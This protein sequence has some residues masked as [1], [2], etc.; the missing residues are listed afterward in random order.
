MLLFFWNAA[1]EVFFLPGQPHFWLFMSALSLGISGVNFVMGRQ[2][3]MRAPEITK[4]IF[5]FLAVIL[6]TAKY[7]GGL[8]F[9]VFGGN[10][11]GGKH[12]VYVLGALL[13]YLALTAQRIPVA[14]SGQVVALYFLSGI[15]FILSNLVYLLGPGFYVL[16]YFL[17]GSVAGTQAASDMGYNVVSRYA[18]LGPVATGLFCFVLA[19]WG[20]RGTLSIRNPW[21]LLLAIIAIAAAFLSGFRSVAAIVF[22]LFLVQFTVEGLWKTFW[23]PIMLGGG[24]LSL[25][26]L[27]LFASRMPAAVQRVLSVFPVNIDPTVRA[28]AENSAFWRFEM[29][30]VV[31]QE[32]P[33]YF[34]MGK[35]YSIDPT[36]LYLVEEGMK[37]GILPDYE[38]AIVAG[39]YH[40][41]L[42]SVIIPFGIFG[43]IGFLWLL[44]A[45]IRVLYSN[46]RYGD[47]KLIVINRLLLS[48]FLTESI[49]FFAVFGALSSQM[50]MFLGVL[51]LSVSLNGGVCRKAV[52]VRKAAEPLPL[53]NP[54]LV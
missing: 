23:L 16:Y 49:L 46:C 33:Q 45:G 26:P 29:F 42:L 7:R 54:A 21:R 53:A 24:I 4:P 2:V 40:D 52:A 9:R 12:Y 13:G 44:L 14:K 36:E 20:I 48:Y 39:D 51:G 3:F 19:R 34:W 10:S 41:G 18:G 5:F 43:L 6:V 25:L 47:P 22:V 32:M 50:M 37:M 35:G 17:P 30:H 8:G 27:V 31:W 11:Y 38:Q 15:T 1:F 28:E